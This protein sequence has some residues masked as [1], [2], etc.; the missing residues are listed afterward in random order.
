MH[1][2]KNSHSVSTTRLI[3]IKCT[4]LCDHPLGQN[5]EHSKHSNA[6]FI[7]IPSKSTCISRGVI[8][9]PPAA[10]FSGSTIGLMPRQL[11]PW[12]AL[13]QGPHMAKALNQTIPAQC[14]T[15]LTACLCSRAPTG[16][17]MIFS[18][19]HCSR[20]N[21]H[22]VSLFLGGSQTGIVVWGLRTYAHSLSPSPSTGISLTHFSHF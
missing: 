12:A 20:P 3:I 16:L 14:R 18:E 7:Q 19:L 5:I 11:S 9:E 6:L 15:P 8:R 22:S 17:A 13:S 2:K 1:V 21:S 10:A 4:H